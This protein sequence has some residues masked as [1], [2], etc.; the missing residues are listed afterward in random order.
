VLVPFKEMLATAEIAAT[1]TISEFLKSAL[2]EA[3]QWHADPQRWQ[4][5]LSRS[6]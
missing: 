5:S 4:N 2:E 3:R 6:D 1:E